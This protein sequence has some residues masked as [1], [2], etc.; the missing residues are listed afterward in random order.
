MCCR[1]GV[2][3][4]PKPPKAVGPMKPTAKGNY[5]EPKGTTSKYSASMASKFK[6][7][8]PTREI[9]PRKIDVIDLTSERSRGDYGKFGLRGYES[10]DK[11]HKSTVKVPPARVIASKKSTAFAMGR[12]TQISFLGKAAGSAKFENETLSDSGDEPMGAVLSPSSSAQHLGLATNHEPFAS[13]N[14]DED[15]SELEAGMVDLDVPITSDDWHQETTERYNSPDPREALTAYHYKETY[16]GDQD[17]HTSEVDE[18][19]QVH[20]TQT[21]SAEK[22]QKLPE[23]DPLFIHTSNPKKLRREISHQHSS[24]E[25]KERPVDDSGTDSWSIAPPRKKRKLSNDADDG[26][27]LRPSRNTDNQIS[28]V[29]RDTKPGWVDGIDPEILAEYGDLVDFY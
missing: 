6:L 20:P 23:D 26:Q 2:D 15:V 8:K 5:G 11:L 22:S 16:T 24:E 29:A 19:T 21:K 7:K 4:R 27:S 1:E 28:L 9:Q 25:M 12:Q 10:L 18:I 3:K 14:F 13:P 17:P